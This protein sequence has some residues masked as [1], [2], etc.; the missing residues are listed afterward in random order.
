MVSVCSY[1][2][3][4][5]VGSVATKAAHVQIPYMSMHIKFTQMASKVLVVA[6]DVWLR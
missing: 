4:G 1:F 6:L 2:D 3:K 5:L